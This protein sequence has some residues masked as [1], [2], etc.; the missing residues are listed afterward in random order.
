[1]LAVGE[2]GHSLRWFSLG[3]RVGG[4]KVKLCIC[5]VCGNN[6]RPAPSPGISQPQSSAIARHH[7]SVQ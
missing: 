5:A 2:Y 6:G 3:A 4:A 7:G 1:M